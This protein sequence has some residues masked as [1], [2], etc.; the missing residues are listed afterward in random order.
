METWVFAYGSN[1]DLEELRSWLS[2]RA[3]PAKFL[4]TTRATLKDHQ[5]V[6][7]Y[8]SRSR[9][10]G[11]AN[12][13]PKA[14]AYVHGL[15]LKVD[16]PTLL[17]I[18]AK[19]G[20]PNFYRRNLVTVET[21]GAAALKAWVYVVQPAKRSTDPEWPSRSYLGLIIEAAK[22]HGLDASYVSELERTPTR[23]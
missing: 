15:A 5:L 23:A 13:E 12:V 14:G 2:S 22:R 9:N 18:D 16:E 7:N 21:T 8:Y 11:A 19:E 10:A 17:G 3:H 6:W 1:M 20:H 4:E